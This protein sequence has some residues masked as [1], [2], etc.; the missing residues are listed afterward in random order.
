MNSYDL[1]DYIKMQIMT[2]LC[3]FLL[4]LVG[5]KLRNKIIWT[6]KLPALS[7][8]MVDRIYIRAYGNPRTGFIFLE[9]CFIPAKFVVERSY[10]FF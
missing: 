4:R 5:Q 3:L 6:K 7:S 2:V 8:C 9:L 10:L 1:D